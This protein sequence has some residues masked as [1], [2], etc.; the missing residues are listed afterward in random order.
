MVFLDN[1]KHDFSTLSKALITMFEN[2]DS[3]YWIKSSIE[4]EEVNEFVIIK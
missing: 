2:N 3:N 4:N 1:K